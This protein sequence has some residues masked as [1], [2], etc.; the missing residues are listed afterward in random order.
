M[1]I[2]HEALVDYFWKGATG[3]PMDVAKLQG[4]LTIEEAEAMQLDI[5]DRWCSRGESLGGWKVGL[6]SG[7]SRDAFG[8][9]V[10]P[11]GHILHNRII[12]SGDEL[13]YSV[14]R[15]CGVENELCFIMDRDLSGLT[16][17]PAMA[18]AAIGGVAPAFEV[19]E[20]RIV[21]ATDGACRVA[22]NLSHWGIVVGE[23]LRFR[24]NDFDFESLSVVLRRDGMEVERV[25]ARGHIDDHFVSIAAL[26]RELAK[27]GRGIRGG[28]R[29]ITGSFTRQSVK[30]PSQWEA[31]FGVFGTVSISF[32]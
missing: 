4:Q 12:K 16:V 2:N 30:G 26:A 3:V 8:K 21:G 27:F 32:G 23:P 28:Q 9:G 10:R 6:T 18:R 13:K 22:D 1:H 11:F 7:S 15:R 20:T 25:D 29:V 24:D 5:L 31:D 19:N 17:T 14:I